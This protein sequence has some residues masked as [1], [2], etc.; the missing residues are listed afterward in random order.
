VGPEAF[1]FTVGRGLAQTEQ[2]LEILASVHICRE[3]SFSALRDLVLDHIGTVSGCVC[4]FLA[5]DE[6]RRD[7]AKLLK[8]VGIPMKIL[9]VVEAGFKGRLEPGPVQDQPDVFHVLEVGSIAEG[10]AKL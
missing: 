8:Q 6:P 3:R 10:L 5:W 1:C 4:V 9:V 7:F 2:M